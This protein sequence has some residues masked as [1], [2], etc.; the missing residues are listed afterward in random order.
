MQPT[1]RPE[2]APEP[3]EPDAGPDTAEAAT[4][5]AEPKMPRVRRRT[6]AVRADKGEEREGRRIYLSDRVYLRV[7]VAAMLQGRKLSDV[8]EDILEKNLPKY[9]ITRT[10]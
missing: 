7:R 2:P 5:S 10:G 4:G 8:V 1:T 6:K 3:E 9:D